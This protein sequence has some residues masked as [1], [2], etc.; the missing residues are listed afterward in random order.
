ME[1]LE[2]A[3][4]PTA[5]GEAFGELRRRE[6]AE[7]YEIRLRNALAQARRFGGREV[8]EA[9]LLTLAFETSCRRAASVTPSS[10]TSFSTTF[11]CACV[12]ER[13]LLLTLTSNH[14]LR[15]QGCPGFHAAFWMVR[16]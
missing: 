14:T 12:Y 7:L 2:L 1:L 11:I 3:G 8:S 15:T 13:L 16:W 5:M 4:S 10:G 9:H 6:I